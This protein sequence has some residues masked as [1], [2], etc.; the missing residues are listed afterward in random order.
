MCKVFYRS[1][2]YVFHAFSHKW[3]RQMYLLRSSM[4]WLCMAPLTLAIITVNG[5]TFHPCALIVSRESNMTW[6]ASHLSLC[7]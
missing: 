7:M 4:L 6:L 1:L 3:D 2:V 5:L